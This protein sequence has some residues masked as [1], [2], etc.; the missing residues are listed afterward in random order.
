VIDERTPRRPRNLYVV[1]G[2]PPTE[3]AAGIKR[4]FR[5]LAA[6]LHPD[7]AGAHGAPR[8]RELVD[9]Y[10]V[11][12]DPVRRA[13]YDEELAARAP[14]PVETSAPAAP[15]ARMSLFRE[16]VTR[17]R[18]RSS[19]IERVD[20]E[21]HLSREEALRGGTVALGV[22]VL[23]PCH[24]AGRGMVAVEEE[25]AVVVP[26]S[27]RDRTLLR[28]PL[29]HLGVAGTEIEILVRVIR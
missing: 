3:S 13:S 26:R 22:P 24:G 9:A 21:L 23:H 25:I 5:E 29:R 2:V 18:R 11:L 7:R 1:L 28:V 14:S 15:L 4:A 19:T 10:R 20:L 27:V 8:F 12:S 17:A 16:L 6:R